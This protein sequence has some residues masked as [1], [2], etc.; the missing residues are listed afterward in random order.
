ATPPATPAAPAIGDLMK[1][2]LTAVEAEDFDVAARTAEAV[3]ARD[4]GNEAARQLRDR[5]RSAEASVNDGLKRARTL[6]AAGQ[7]EEALRAAGDVLSHAPSNNEALRIMQ[8]ANARSRGRGADEARAQ[9]ARARNAAR[10]AGA[11]RL[12]SAQY[13]AAVGVER[14]AERLFDAGRLSE[15]TVRFYEASR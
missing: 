2:A 7:Y 4:P 15:A 3:L 8:D 1:T 11:Q 13:A 10:T 12:A 14:D 6:M 9:S 5:A